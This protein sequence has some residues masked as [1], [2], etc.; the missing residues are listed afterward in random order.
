MNELIQELTMQANDETGN[1]FDLNHKELNVFL[2]KFAELLVSEFYTEMTRQ[3][4][5]CRVDET[6]NPNAFKAVEGA[7]KHFGVEK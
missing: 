6:N 5:W 2:E 7:L 1:L 3:M 4:Y